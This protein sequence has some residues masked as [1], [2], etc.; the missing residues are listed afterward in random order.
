MGTKIDVL[1]P[2]LDF[3]GNPTILF[4]EG[5]FQSL[6]SNRCGYFAIT[7]LIERSFNLDLKYKTLL[8]EIFNKECEI[9]E[10][11]VVEFCQNL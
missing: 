11:I 5:A 8:A 4:N 10:K 7:F 6:T 3:T 1:K 9:N 2:F